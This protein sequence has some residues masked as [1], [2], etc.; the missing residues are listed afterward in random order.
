V[1]RS[2]MLYRDKKVVIVFVHFFRAA[3][4]VT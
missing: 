4:S 2:D 3:E 1:L